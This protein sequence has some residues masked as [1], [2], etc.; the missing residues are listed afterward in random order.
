MAGPQIQGQVTYRLD[1]KATTAQRDT[2]AAQRSKQAQHGDFAKL[3][4][5]NAPVYVCLCV[6]DPYYKTSL[7]EDYRI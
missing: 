3:F 7:W 5:V 2:W 4:G 1:I 6:F